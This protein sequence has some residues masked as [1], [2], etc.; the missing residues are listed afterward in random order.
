MGVN[1]I[2]KHTGSKDKPR[3]LKNIKNLEKMGFIESEDSPTHTQKKIKQLSNLGKEMASLSQDLHDL[4]RWYLTLKRSVKVNFAT[5]IESGSTVSES[6][7]SKLKFQG[8]KDDEVKKYSRYHEGSY[9]LIAK[10]WNTAFDF[11]I[12]R[13][14]SILYKFKF[15]KD[16]E[17]LLKQIT[18]DWMTQHIGSIQND[19]TQRNLFGS[20]ED[21]WREGTVGIAWLNELLYY[22]FDSRY[23]R[24]NRFTNSEAE[25]ALVDIM[26]IPRYSQENLSNLLEKCRS[27]IEELHNGGKMDPD[28][29]GEYENRMKIL[30]KLSEKS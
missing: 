24:Y 29:L 27:E 28:E 9:Q 19:Y 4:T 23:Y 8:W 16:S 10:L 21:D 3:M 18:I 2:C 13:Y 20:D 6:A 11:V 15:K 12:I 17:D 1:Q 22:A 7:I 25:I 30:E 5:S 26:R 14:S